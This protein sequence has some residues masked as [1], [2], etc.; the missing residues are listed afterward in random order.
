MT[1][2]TK[3]EISESSGPVVTK[4]GNLCA[5]PELR[6]SEKGSPYCRL[7]LAISTP[8][9]PGDWKGER[10][11]TFYGVTAFGSLAE[12]AAESLQKGDRIVVTG[13]GEIRTWTDDAGVEHKEKVILADAL[14]PDLRWADAEVRRV[15]ASRPIEPD[16][17]E[18]EPF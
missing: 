16:V 3:K 9:T 14:G 10:T 7:R 8:V 2:R 12:N 18:E 1:T 6:F 5:D 13:P 17:V 15:R 11:T 4:V